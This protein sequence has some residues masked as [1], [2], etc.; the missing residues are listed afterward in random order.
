MNLYETNTGQYV[1]YKDYSNSAI[2]TS[3]YQSSAD[4]TNLASIIRNAFLFFLDQPSVDEQLLFNP[5]LDIKRKAWDT[6]LTDEELTALYA[7][8]AEE[9]KELVQLGLVHYAK[10]LKHEEEIE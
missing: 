2:G 3:L 6:P 4:P 9:D 10:V 5:E 8:A 7:E 1:L